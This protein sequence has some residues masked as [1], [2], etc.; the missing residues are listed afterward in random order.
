MSIRF[1]CPDCGSVLKIKEAL[2]STEGKC[3]KCKRPFTV[4]EAS[5]DVS[6]AVPDADTSPGAVETGTI[7]SPPKSKG[8]AKIPAPAADGAEF[9]PVAFLMEGGAPPKAK[10]KSSAPGPAD[11]GGLSLDDGEP[12]PGPK[13]RPKPAAESTPQPP[14]AAASAKGML[15]AS[16]NAK[17]LLTRTVEESRARA[18][19]MPEESRIPLIDTAQLKM[20]LFTKILPFGGATIVICWLFYWLANSM[21][22]DSGLK[23]P[24]ELVAAQGVVLI[25]GKPT[26]GVSVFMRFMPNA[27]DP[28]AERWRASTAI[29]NEDGEFEMMFLEGYEGVVPGRQQ[30]SLSYMVNGLETIDSEYAEPGKLQ[31]IDESNYDLKIEST[32]VI[33]IPPPPPVES[34]E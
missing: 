13:S 8:R 33:R 7:A 19:E 23:L 16:S 32:A 1:E 21:Y 10:A 22:G 27:D 24:E 9:D 6:A 2:A 20:L 3:P 18:A 28:N 15:S 5:P 4:P 34:T 17:D 30:V 12:S 31:T 11:R 14:T 26:E 25:N 29:T